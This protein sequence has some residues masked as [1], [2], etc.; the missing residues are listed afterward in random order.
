MLCA[1]SVDLDEV[2]CY[3]ALH[4]LWAH[5]EGANAVYDVALERIAAWAAALDLP[6]S[7]FAIGRDLERSRSAER[8]REMAEAGHE[9][10]NHS[11]GH[12]YDLTRLSRPA[13]AAEVRRGADAIEAATGRRPEGFRAPGYSISDELLDALCDEGVRF[14]ASVFPCAGYYA[15]KLAAMAGT[16]LRGRQTAAVVGDPRVALAPA[17][18][19][20]PGRPWFEHGERPLVELPIA[21]TRRM[22]LP[23]IGTALT[24]AGEGG[25]RRLARGV[26]GRPLV[27]LELHGIDFLDDTDG[28]ADLVGHQPDVRIPAADKQRR[29]SAAIDVLRDAGYR[30]VTLA[31]AAQ[32]F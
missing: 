29:V 2:G 8:L 21:V 24:V 17:D 30:F 7:L 19:Y 14:D 20:R 12:R 23:V 11:F 10:E 32:R 4:G 26:V 31:T 16:S 13:I 27:S 18:P 3:R 9:V 6:L 5:G 15:A 25:A 28:L 22:R 1:V